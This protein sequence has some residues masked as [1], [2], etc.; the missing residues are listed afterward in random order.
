MSNPITKGL[1]PRCNTPGPHFVGPSFGMTGFFACDPNDKPTASRT[2][3]HYAYNCAVC[4]TIISGP[5]A[6]SP[7]AWRSA[8][9]YVHS[10]CANRERDL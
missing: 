10:R 4:R 3:E 2:P 6:E 9:P 7:E 1:C 8:G 5:W